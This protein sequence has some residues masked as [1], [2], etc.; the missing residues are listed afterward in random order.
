M[1]DTSW[2][3]VYSNIASNHKTG[4]KKNRKQAGLPDKLKGF[5]FN[6]ANA[7]CLLCGGENLPLSHADAQ[8]DDGCARV[9]QVTQSIKL[10]D[11]TEYGLMG[12]VL[13]IDQMRLPCKV[14]GTKGAGSM[15]KFDC[16]KALAMRKSLGHQYGV[17]K[18]V[19]PKDND[20]TWRG[21]NGHQ[22][23]VKCSNTI[24]NGRLVTYVVKSSHSCSAFS[25]RLREV[26]RKFIHQIDGVNCFVYNPVE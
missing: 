1:A 4:P 22:I 20:Q 12:K 10:R 17:R 19:D 3:P 23:P 15:N 24:R 11:G 8:T 21:I 2:T 13:N 14:F 16:R 7:A 18:I 26:D 6:E 25:H 5:V 9:F